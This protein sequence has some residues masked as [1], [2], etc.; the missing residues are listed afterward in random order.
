MVVSEP[1]TFWP[2]A[3]RDIDCATKHAEVSKFGLW[4][5]IVI[6]LFSKYQHFSMFSDLV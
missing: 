5:T 1:S 6:F 2:E 4:A 3:L